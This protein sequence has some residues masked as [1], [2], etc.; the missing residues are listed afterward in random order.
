VSQLKF[1]AIAKIVLMKTITT[2]Q[3]I[4][5]MRALT[6]IGVPFAFTYQTYSETKKQ[7]NGVRNVDRALLRPGLRN[8]QSDKADTL[9]AFTEYP[10]GE[11]KFFHLGLLLT[12]NDYKID[13]RK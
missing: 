12:F 7:T 5:K 2:I 3:A 10:S 1:I 13:N 11:P 9:V 8:D 4:K 6:K